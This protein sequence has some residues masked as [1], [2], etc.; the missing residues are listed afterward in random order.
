MQ[1]HHFINLFTARYSIPTAPTLISIIT[2]I[3]TK[4]LN[5]TNI[6]LILYILFRN[7]SSDASFNISVLHPIVA[8][9][10]VPLRFRWWGGGRQKC[11]NTITL[12]I[13]IQLTWN[14]VQSF[15]PIKTFKRCPKRISPLSEVCWLQQLFYGFPENQGYSKF[16]L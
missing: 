13:Y 1:N 2:K 12:E 15:I 8:V 5:G 3:S 16:L 11:R 14:L 10:L 4:L 7:W 9:V 6:N